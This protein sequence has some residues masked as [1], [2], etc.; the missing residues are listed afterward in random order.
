MPSSS[1]RSRPLFAE[2]TP[3]GALQ[4]ALAPRRDRRPAPCPRRPVGR[5]NGVRAICRVERGW[6]P[7]P[8]LSGKSGR[9]G[10]GAPFPN[11]SGEA[12]RG[13]GGTA[14]G[15]AGA[16]ASTPIRSAPRG[17][18]NPRTERTQAPPRPARRAPRI[19]PARPTR[20]RLQPARA[21]GARA[22][23]WLP[24]E[25]EAPPSRASSAAPEP[26]WRTSCPTHPRPAPACTSPRSSGCR[27]NPSR[28]PCSRRRRPFRSRVVSERGSYHS[29]R[30]QTI[31]SGRR[32][33]APDSA[34]AVI[35]ATMI[36]PPISV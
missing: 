31:G 20:A 29:R 11:Q 32:R 34:C 26:G 33:R 15:R 1:P 3:A 2:L 28:R 5:R 23:P 6:G 21:R 24:N 4:L 12:Q 8:Q 18:S 13:G 25:P 36:A 17:C 27:T 35:A 7:S 14:G 30:A 10:V 9:K 16:R 19:R 22:A